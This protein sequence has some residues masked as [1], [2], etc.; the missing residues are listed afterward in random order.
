MLTPWSNHVTL[1]LN[2]LR[3]MLRKEILVGVEI[4]ANGFFVSFD[5]C[6]PIFISMEDG[7]LSRDGLPTDCRYVGQ[8]LFLFFQKQ[9][10]PFSQLKIQ[11]FIPNHF[12][13]FISFVTTEQQSHYI[14]HEMVLEFQEKCGLNL[15]R[16]FFHHDAISCCD[17]NKKLILGWGIKKEIIQNFK[18]LFS[19][20]GLKKEILFSPANGFRGGI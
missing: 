13:E 11:F 5:F 1:F 18:N 10:I 6:H 3:T 20:F 12:W 9:G 2:Q 15:T 14:D 7:F 19:E 4:A 8:V 17:S 16:Y